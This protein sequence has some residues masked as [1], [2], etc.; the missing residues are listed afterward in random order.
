MKAFKGI[1][2][3]LSTA[4]TVALAFGAWK[5]GMIDGATAW[6]AIGASAP[7][8]FAGLRANRVKD[9]LGRSDIV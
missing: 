1:R 3:E 9:G 5:F 4:L 2:T 6:L 7:G 8:L